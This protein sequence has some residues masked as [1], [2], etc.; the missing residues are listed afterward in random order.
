[1]SRLH[2]PTR[3]LSRSG[4]VKVAAVM[5]VMQHLRGSR[6]MK[7]SPMKS[8]MKLSDVTSYVLEGLES[9]MRSAKRGI[10][11]TVRSE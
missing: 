6:L 1:M 11:R 10:E 2:C 5:S 4:L 8:L 9:L 3:H 7:M